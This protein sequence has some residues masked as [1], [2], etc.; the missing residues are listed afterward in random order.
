MAYG[1]SYEYIEL[2]GVCDICHNE[3]RVPELTDT[4]EDYFEF[5]VS[6]NK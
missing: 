3:V 4:N 1:K 5:I 6:Q 2:F